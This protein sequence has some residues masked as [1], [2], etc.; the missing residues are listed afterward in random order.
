[1]KAWRSTLFFVFHFLFFTTCSAQI[2]STIAGNG[3]SGFSGNGG[4]ATV[5]EIIPNQITMDIWGNMY[6]SDYDTIVRKLDTLGIISAFAGNGYPGGGYSGDGGPAMSAELEFPAGMATDDSGNVFIADEANNVIRKVNTS[7]IIS[8]FAGI[9]Y[10]GSGGGGYSGD[11]GPATVAEFDDPRDVAVDKSGNVYIADTHNQV[12]RQVNTSGIINTF[13]GNGFRTGILG[14]QGGFSGDG[15]PATAAEFWDPVSVVVDNSGNVY[16][17]DME[18]SRIRKVSTSDTITTIAGNGV[19]GF[20]GDGG[21]ATAA[22]IAIIPPLS[23]LTVDDSGNI[24]LPDAAYNHIRKIN[25]TGII[26]TIA[27][28]GYGGFSGDGGQATNAELYGPTDVIL[29]RYGNIYIADL[30]DTRI[31]KIWMVLAVFANSIT[32]VSCNGASN[33]STAI[34]AS[35]GL[36]PYTYSWSN[37]ATTSSVSNLSAGTYTINVVDSENIKGSIVVTITQPT[38]LGISTFAIANNN[39]YGEN[40]GSASSTVSG[41]TIPYTYLWSDANSQTTVSA[42]GLSAGSYTLTTTDSNSCTA[43]TVVSIS[44]PAAIIPSIMEYAGIKCNGDSDATLFAD[45]TGG[46]GFYAYSW[47]DASSQATALATGLSAGNYTL[48]VTDNNGC[49][50]TSSMSI[51]QPPV[52]S[53]V[54]DSINAT[55]GNCNGSAWV[56]VT[57]GTPLYTYLWTGGL[58]TDTIR[59]QC[60]GNYCSTVTDANGC[61]DSVCINI[62][63]STG[64]NNVDN[65]S[66]INIYPNPNSGIF[67][68]NISNAPHNYFVEIYNVL[69]ENIYSEPFPKAHDDNAINLIGQPN[70]I[71]FYRVLKENGES[72]GNGKLIIVQ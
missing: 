36:T 33:G 54:A 45:A 46:S 30:T 1:M 56:M 59:N 7:G 58:I 4:P 13:A 70:G 66:I 5:A 62:D 42:T 61:I 63:V 17:T 43:S 53:I 57:G 26:N 32:N 34:S 14:Q 69:G 27:G 39:C 16:I 8:T 55:N 50:G 21:L 23:T 52:L 31:R 44:Q 60:T 29:D 65:S 18:N 28:N 37:G 12:I 22:E 47:S 11:G 10:Y 41:G 40:N 64:I 6:I 15:G 71:Y 20:A 2:I 9:R 49:T 19:G 25:T 24:Y 68:L 48:A 72:V 67:T 38:A 3:L 51:T 35:E